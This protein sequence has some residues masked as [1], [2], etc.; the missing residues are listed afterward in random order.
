MEL[1][2]KIFSRQNEEF[3]SSGCIQVVREFPKVVLAAI[4]KQEIQNFYE[5]PY[6]QMEIAKGEEILDFCWGFHRLY[7]L[8]D[9]YSSV[10]PT[11]VFYNLESDRIEYIIKKGPKEESKEPFALRTSRGL[12]PCSYELGL[13]VKKL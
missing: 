2:Y 4:A 12:L 1:V 11:K 10:E 6:P 5:H 7:F 8:E 9:G 13:T 3:L